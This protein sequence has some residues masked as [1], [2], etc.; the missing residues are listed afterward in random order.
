MDMTELETLRR[1]KMYLEKL[2]A[3]IDPISGAAVPAGEVLD[4]ERLR[5]CFSYVCGVLEGD[6]EREWRKVSKN[7]PVFHMDETRIAG[8]RPLDGTVGVRQLT[9]YIN[10]QAGS[11]LMRK[12]SP[13]AI[14]GWLVEAGMLALR[15]N[16]SGKLPTPSGTA[17]G[18]ITE[19]RTSSTGEYTAVLYT[20]D[21]Q[22]FILDHLPTILAHQPVPASRENQGAS[23]TREEE[24]FALRQYRSGMPLQEIAGALKRTREGVRAHLQKL[25]AEPHNR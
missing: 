19:E 1:A 15:D 22:Q 2:A 8:L 16:A 20:P 11:S 13:T 3:G 7:L 23:W 24:E 14:T 9:D 4:Q 5:R 25:G 6:I 10:G 18:I 17:L 12:L 21:A